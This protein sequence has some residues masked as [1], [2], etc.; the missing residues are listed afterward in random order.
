MAVRAEDTGWMGTKTKGTTATSCGKC[1]GGV[2][3]DMH[4]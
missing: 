3:E 1:D 4:A 2:R